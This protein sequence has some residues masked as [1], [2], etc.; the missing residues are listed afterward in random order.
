MIAFHYFISL[1]ESHTTEHLWAAQPQIA[2]NNITFT[3]GN[4]HGKTVIGHVLKR[5]YRNRCWSQN[6]RRSLYSHRL[7]WH[8]RLI[9]VSKCE[10]IF[11][12]IQVVIGVALSFY[13]QIFVTTYSHNIMHHQRESIAKVWHSINT[14]IYIEAYV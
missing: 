13:L 1:P 14:H 8:F 12:S 6:H 2:Q 4:V 9:L 11:A 5:Q 7:L 3:F 10:W